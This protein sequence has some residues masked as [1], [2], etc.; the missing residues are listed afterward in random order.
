M[1]ML[2]KKGIR[3]A[4]SIGFPDINFDQIMNVLMV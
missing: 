2:G 4:G 1:R 3:A